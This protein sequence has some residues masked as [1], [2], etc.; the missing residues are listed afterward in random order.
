MPRKPKKKVKV[1]KPA[2]TAAAPCDDGLCTIKKIYRHFQTISDGAEGSVSGFNGSLRPMSIARVLRALNVKGE[3][4]VD[5]GAGSG[6]VILSAVVEGAS[7]SYGYELPEN[8]GMK[9]VFDSVV[10]TSA[11]PTQDRVEWIG[12]D[13]ME[14]TELKGSPSCVFSFWVGF[15]LHVQEHLLDLCSKT[16]SVQTIAVFKDVKWGK[17]D[18][19]IFVF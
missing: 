18:Q 8:K 6:R 17:A 15:P 19:G 13:I 11:F 7:L 12:K 1:V 16:A 3:E 14:L 4:V 5:F 10:N 2:R 9:A